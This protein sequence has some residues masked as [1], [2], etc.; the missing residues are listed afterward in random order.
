MLD[1]LVLKQNKR[2]QIITSTLQRY[3]AAIPAGLLHKWSTSSE[4]EQFVWHKVIIILQM[5]TITTRVFVIH[6]FFISKYLRDKCFLPLHDGFEYNDGQDCKYL[7]IWSP[8]MNN[9]CLQ[10]IREVNIIKIDFSIFFQ[11]PKWLTSVGSGRWA[12]TQK[13]LW[14][15]VQGS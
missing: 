6:R 12:N 5:P 7:L 13:A 1:S 4:V 8:V 2:C 14:I 10:V 15:Y 9:Y 3:T 11:S